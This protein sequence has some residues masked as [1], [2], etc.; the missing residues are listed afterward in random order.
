VVDTLAA[1][2]LRERC[3]AAG[4]PVSCTAEPGLEAV[5][6]SD[7][8]EALA[9]G[10]LPP[11]RGVVLLDEGPFP[12]ELL[13]G[14][15]FDVVVSLTP[16][17]AWRSDLTPVVAGLLAERFDIVPRHGLEICLGEAIANA[18]IHGN[19]GLTG[20][21][22]RAARRAGTLARLVEVCRTDPAHRGRRLQ[23]TACVS[24]DRVAFSVRDEGSGWNPDDCVDQGGFGRRLLA[25]LAA[26]VIYSENG[27]RVTFT[28]NAGPGASGRPA[29]EAADGPDRNLSRG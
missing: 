8:F 17:T 5:M 29:P 13:P 14:F 9:T 11:R 23:I 3:L 24:D 10:L 25:R 4:I 6:V 19:L 22:W 21:A 26:D 16:D 12:A 2:G 15:P 28:L 27:T 7:R 20:R 1:A 18:V